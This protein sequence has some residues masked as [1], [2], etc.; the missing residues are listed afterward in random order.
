MLIAYHR[1]AN[2]LWIMTIHLSFKLTT[3]FFIH[4]ALH[5][6]KPF[7]E[8]LELGPNLQNIREKNRLVSKEDIGMS[9]IY[10]KIILLYKDNRA[11]M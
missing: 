2:T 8:M 7:S 10:L 6:M 9:G 11:K 1:K 5:T 3:Q 4:N